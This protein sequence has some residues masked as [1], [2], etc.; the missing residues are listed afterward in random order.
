[1]CE[2]APV[3]RVAEMVSEGNMTVRRID[4]KR[5]KRMLRHYNIPE[6]THIAVDEVY[7]RKK[8]KFT[9]EDRDQRFF[10]VITDLRTRRVI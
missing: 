2:F 5:M 8:K 9:D 7:A 4:F 10:T 6:V 1:M 3:S